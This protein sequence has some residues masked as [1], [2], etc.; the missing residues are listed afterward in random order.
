MPFQSVLGLYKMQ[1]GL[2]RNWIWVANS[3]SYYD[4]H[5]TK[6]TSCDV[7]VCKLGNQTIVSES[8]SCCVPHTSGFELKLG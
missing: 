5:C 1:T 2:F 3:I 6:N 8:T 4:N 7:M